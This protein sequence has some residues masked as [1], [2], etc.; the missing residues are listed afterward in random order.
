MQSD[1]NSFCGDDVLDGFNMSYRE[2]DSILKQKYE[3]QI[4][5]DLYL[6]EFIFQKYFKKYFLKRN[7]AHNKKELIKLGFR[8]TVVLVSIF[9]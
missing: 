3:R 9:V 8:A 1:G 7:T 6:G 5:W 4:S 2:E